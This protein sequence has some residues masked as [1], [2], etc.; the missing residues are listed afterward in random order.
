MKKYSRVFGYLSHYKSSI[1]WYFI[2]IL[3]SIV[4]SIVSIGM[5]LPFMQLI[6]DVQQVSV[7]KSSGNF[8]MQWVSTNL[9]GLIYTG[10]KAHDLGIVCILIIVFIFSKNLFLYM[11]YRAMGPVK[12]GIVNRFRL[13]LY[14]K[15]LLLPIGY[16]TE[17]R[18]GDL[19]SRVTTMLAKLRV[20]SWAH[21][22]DG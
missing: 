15:I 11:S 17:K 1:V 20:R 19:M 4:F 21:L 9:N 22:K 7:P 12:N 2:S 8:L 5:L 18:K 14:N 6:F 10:D 13:E 3:F 16:F